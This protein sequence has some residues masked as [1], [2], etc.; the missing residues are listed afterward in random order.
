MKA[1]VGLWLSPGEEGLV[2]TSL[3][4]V[5][6]GDEDVL[7]L[8]E[9]AWEE[10]KRRPGRIEVSDPG[11]HSLL[12]ERLGSSGIEVALRERLKDVDRVLLSMASR[13]GVPD[14]QSALDVPGVT[15]ESMQRFARAAR[16]LFESAPWRHLSDRDLIEIRGGVPPGFQHAVVLGMSR[17]TLGLGFFEDRDAFWDVASGKAREAT[18]QWL[19]SYEP[20]GMLPPG[21]ARFFVEHGLDAACPHAYPL[22]RRFQS[23]LTV[24]RPSGKVLEFLSGLLEAI[25]S[26]G[27]DDFDRGRWERT[28]ETGAGARKYDFV[29]PYLLEPPSREELLRRGIVPD[30]RAFERLQFLLNRRL[31]GR[32]PGSMEAFQTIVEREF[33]GKPIDEMPY[34]PKDDRERAQ[35]LCF[36][37]FDAWGRRQ[38][39]L[40]DRALALDPECVDALVLKGERTHELEEALRFFQR[41]VA[42]GEKSLEAPEAREGVGEL[43]SYYPTRPTLR[44]LHALG[45]ALEQSGEPEK[46]ADCYQRLLVLD[47]HDHQGVRYCRLSCLL[48]AELYREAQAHVKAHQE[49]GE[50]LWSYARARAAFGRHGDGRKAR[51]ALG[52][53]IQQNPLAALFLLDADVPEGAAEPGEEEDAERCAQELAHVWAETHGA[54]RWLSRELEARAS[55]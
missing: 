47:E 23:Q 26:S 34:E 16:A 13:F 9:E 11:L 19:L 12:V 1:W 49:K 14:Y 29:L 50:C 32:E 8:L 20:I 52:R 28:V 48:G 45:H 54:L 55:R 40:A 46:A 53:A 6:G 39:L 4:S 44:A 30:R 25:A 22:A 24:K 18:G 15:V 21:D 5:R 36:E 17:T 38:I 10:W 7:S 42:A 2:G 43:W 35:E 3:R 33:Q 31:A 41:A 51:E 37:A 27:P